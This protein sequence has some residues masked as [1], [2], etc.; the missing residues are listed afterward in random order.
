MLFFRLRY[1]QPGYQEVDFHFLS[2]DF[3][4]SQATASKMLTSL[5]G[6]STPEAVLNVQVV[7]GVMLSVCD[8]HYT[9]RSFF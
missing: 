6:Y 7:Y 4:T 9:G 2:A 8:P 3:S 5:N 1:I